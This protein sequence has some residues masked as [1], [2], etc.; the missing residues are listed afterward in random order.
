[1]LED[2]TINFLHVTAKPDND[3]CPALPPP[4]TPP[5]QPDPPTK[6]FSFGSVAS[7]AVSG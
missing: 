4:S 5:G 2:R 1:M 6:S 7:A 3:D